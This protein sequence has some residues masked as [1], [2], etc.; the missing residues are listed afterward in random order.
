[1]IPARQKWRGLVDDLHG[2][3]EYKDRLKCLFDYM[4]NK[5]L[6]AIEKRLINSCPSFAERSGIAARSERT[7]TKADYQRA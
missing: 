1:M 7:R 2:P 5:D 3:K 6:H 4:Q